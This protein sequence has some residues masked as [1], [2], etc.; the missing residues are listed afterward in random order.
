MNTS[1]LKYKKH[2]QVQEEQLLTYQK[3]M[4]KIV[5]DFMISPEKKLLKSSPQRTVV[6]GKLNLDKIN[7]SI[8]KMRNDSL[9]KESFMVK[10]GRCSSSA[11][12]SSLS[13]QSSRNKRSQRSVTSQKVQVKFKLVA[14]YLCVIFEGIK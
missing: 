3:Q 10:N 1:N 2:R 5:N 4:R 8:N 9:E 12:S 14:L 6:T 11:T 7:I 13:G